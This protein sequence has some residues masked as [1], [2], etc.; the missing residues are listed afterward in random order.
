MGLNLIKPLAYAFAVIAALWF[1]FHMGGKVERAEI[2]ARSA[3]VVATLSAE[4][5]TLKKRSLAAEA[6]LKATRA[7]RAETLEILTDE[8][9]Q[10]PDAARLALGVDGVRRLNRAR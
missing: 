10:D 9:L 6:A 3:E 7:R 1:A 4:L 5:D 2:E 8:L